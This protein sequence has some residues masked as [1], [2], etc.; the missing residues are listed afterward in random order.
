[1]KRKSKNENKGQNLKL[2]LIFFLLIAFL[3]TGSLIFKAGLLAKK[4]K[5]D[6]QHRFTTVFFKE[7]NPGR[8]KVFSFAPDTKT[9]SILLIDKKAYPLK[10]KLLDIEKYLGISI[11]GFVSLDVIDEA[12]VQTANSILQKTVFNF[13]KAKTNLTIIDFIR[14]WFFTRTVS[15]RAITT[16]EVNSVIEVGQIDKISNSLFNDSTLLQENQSIQVVNATDIAGLGGRLSRFLGNMGGSVV[17][18]V[19]PK[20]NS[21]DS[22][23]IYFGKKTYTAERLGKILGFKIVDGGEDQQGESI[24]DIVII[25]GK[26][27]LDLIPF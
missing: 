5:F 14:L 7:N 16:E 2:A 12:K 13:N 19:T 8:V 24:S 26:D 22:K 10:P 6:G 15:S 20:K 4:S 11:D 3:I 17:S 1:M 27:K 25:I 9:I 23:I 18:V 21:D